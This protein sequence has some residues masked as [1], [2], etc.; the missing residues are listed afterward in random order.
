MVIFE[1]EYSTLGDSSSPGPT[2]KSERRNY[3]DRSTGQL[4]SSFLLPLTLTFNQGY[5]SVDRKVIEP[6]G[7]AARLRPLYLKPINLRS[8]ADA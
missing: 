7:C 4:G 6:L 1:T 2:H 8:L 3:Q 5:V